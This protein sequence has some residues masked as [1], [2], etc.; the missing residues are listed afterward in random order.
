MR[1]DPRVRSLFDFR[2]EHFE[3]CDY[4][5]HPRIPAPVAV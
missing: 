2:Y 1:L 3:L 5:Y 4:R